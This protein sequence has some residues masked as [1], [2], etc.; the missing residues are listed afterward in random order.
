M[1]RKS[2]VINYIRNSG[3]YTDWQQGDVDNDNI[4]INSKIPVND[5]DFAF[6]ERVTR[7]LALPARRRPKQ[8]TRI[9]LASSPWKGD[10][11]PLYDTCSGRRGKGDIIAFIWYPHTHAKYKYFLT[12]FFIKDKIL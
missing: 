10:I 9:G 6:R 3:F 2:R 11:I 5:G 8:V 1:L 7:I 12:Y 4:Y